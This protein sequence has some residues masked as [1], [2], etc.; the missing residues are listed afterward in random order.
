LLYRLG[1]ISLYNAVDSAKWTW[2][3]HSDYSEKVGWFTL[4]TIYV[5]QFVVFK[6]TNRIICLVSAVTAM[7]STI[8]LSVYHVFM[9]WDLSTDVGLTFVMLV[10]AFGLCMAVGLVSH[11]HLNKLVY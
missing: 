9:T 10:L 2:W 1:W 8:L 3:F 4:S 5:H 7:S 11:C 6:S